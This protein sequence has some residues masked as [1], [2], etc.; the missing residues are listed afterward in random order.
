VLSEAI[1]A[2]LAPSPFL[3]TAVVGAS[4][5]VRAGTA[6]QRAQILPSI[7]AGGT[8]VAPAIDEL[9]KHDPEHVQTTARRAGDGFIIDGEKCFVLDGHVADWLVVSARTSP[10]LPASA[11]TTLFLVSAQ[12]PGIDIERT[13][14]VDWNNAARVRFSG[15]KVNA[16]SVMGELDQG[17]P[18]LEAVLDIGRA[19]ASAQLLGLA[20]EVFQRT[21]GYLKERRQFDRPVGSFQALQHRAA[22]LSI[23]IELT[24]ALVSSAQDALDRHANEASALV[25]AAKAMAGTTANKAVCEAVQM[26]GGIGMT[27]ELDVGF[28]MKRARVLDALWGDANFHVDRYARLSGF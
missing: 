8:V 17:A 9:P 20:E 21:L 1:G 26:H 14:M 2:A 28:F 18:V 23:D 11:V 13:I 15:V 27:D 22:V 10:G 16:D 7:A 5:L 25:S 3:S 12:T 24:R 19:M 4:A 6:A